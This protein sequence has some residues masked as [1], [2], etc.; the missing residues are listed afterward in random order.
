WKSVDERLEQLERNLQSS[1]GAIV[2][3]IEDRR[4]DTTA[5]SSS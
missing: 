4:P 2:Y 1:G 3:R 5:G